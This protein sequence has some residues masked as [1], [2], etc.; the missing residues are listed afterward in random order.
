M[1]NYV[2]TTT[3]RRTEHANLQEGIYDERKLNAPGIILP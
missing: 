3:P 2:S 1:S